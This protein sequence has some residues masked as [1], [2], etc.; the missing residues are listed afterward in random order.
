MAGPLTLFAAAV[1]MAATPLWWP[2]GAA[3]VD[4]LVFAILLFPAFWAVYVFYALIES[5]PVRGLI[6]MLAAIGLNGALIAM[7]F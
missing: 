3:G 2:K 1:T 6:V 4:H 5:R 7:Q